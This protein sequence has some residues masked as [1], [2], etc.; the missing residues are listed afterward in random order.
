MQGQGGKG[1][2]P[3]DPKVQD[4]YNGAY[5]RLPPMAPSDAGVPASGGA[6]AAYPVAEP[7]VSMYAYSMSICSGLSGEG[8]KSVST[9]GE[10]STVA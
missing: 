10:D 3:Y 4:A 2:D 5:D 6:L 8:I 7:Q 9:C 1:A